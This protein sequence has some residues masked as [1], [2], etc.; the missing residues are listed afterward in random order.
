ML[1]QIG[2]NSSNNC[3]RSSL[4]ITV[5]KFLCQETKRFPDH[6]TA[7]LRRLV[8]ERGF[9]PPTP[10]SR[11]RFQRL[12]DSIEFC[13]SQVIRVERVAVHALGLVELGGFVVL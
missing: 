3:S 13:R 11:T 2:N 9:E 10:C 4:L 6:I 5:L 7:I 12:L 8:G 1:R